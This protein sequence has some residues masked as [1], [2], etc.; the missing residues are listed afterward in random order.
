M[1]DAYKFST[2]VKDNF[3]NTFRFFGENENSATIIA[4]SIAV[5]KG[6]FRPLFTMMDKK[7]DPDTKKYTAIREGLTELAALPLYAITPWVAGKLVDKFV[8][9]PDVFATKRIKTNAKFLGICAAT[10]IIPAVCNLVQPPIMKA[11]KKHMEAKK[12]K[13]QIGSIQQPTKPSTP[14]NN[15]AVKPLSTNLGMR[16][17]N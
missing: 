12:A 14:I 13:T 3:K 4:C 16:V 6:F 15:I 8:K 1:A 2:L 10:L 7:S 9:N 11:Y 17:G 5:F